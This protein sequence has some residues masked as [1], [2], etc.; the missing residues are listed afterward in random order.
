MA[1]NLFAMAEINPADYQYVSQIGREALYEATT[2][3]VARAM[4]HMNTAIRLFVE[5]D[6]PNYSERYFLPM[7]GRMDEVAEG[8]DAPLVTMTG[9]WDVAYPIFNHENGVKVTD[10]QFAYMPPAQFQS[11]IDGIVG[12]YRNAVRHAILR[13]LF[14]NAAHSVTDKLWGTLS[15]K[16]LA[17][18]DGTEYPPVVGSDALQTTLNHYVTSGY[19]AANINNT[20]NPFPTLAAL[21]HAQFGYETGGQPIYAFI[22]SAQRAKVE[23][24]TDFEK[25][26]TMGVSTASDTEYRVGFN[27]LVDPAGMVIGSVGEVIISIWDFIPANY[28]YAQHAGQPAPLKRR[29]DP[30]STGL[31]GGTLQLLETV[32]E[33]KLL[34][35]DWRAR[36]G[37]GVGNRLNGVVMHLTDGAFAVPALYDWAN[38]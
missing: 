3:Y 1:G 12:R 16:P 27:D 26:S 24:L 21:F 2:E 17:N 9:S 20:N 33:P 23:A 4:E 5:G 25:V 19:T 13:A 15:I 22:N 14:N 38:Q 7:T 34:Y 36:F 31:G 29:V 30:A 18:N 32:D 6:T 11:H 10:V 37:F 8:S 28:I 35:S